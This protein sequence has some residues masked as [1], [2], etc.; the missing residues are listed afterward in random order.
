MQ[1]MK[2]G[3][4]ALRDAESI[5]KAVQIIKDQKTDSMVII[6]SAMDK[7]TNALT[8]LAHLAHTQQE[9]SAWAAYEHI[10]AFHL[11]VC[12]ELFKEHEPIAN[13]QIQAYLDE[14]RNLLQ[15]ILLLGKVPGFWVSGN[16]PDLMYDHIIAYGELLSS[17]LLAHYLKHS[18]VS[19]LWTDVRELVRTDSEAGQ[20][21]V[22]WNLTREN[23]QKFYAEHKV[24]AEIILTQGF[25]GSNLQGQTTTLGREGS[26][27]SAAIFA[28]CLSAEKL[29]VWKDVPGIMSS[30]PKDHKDARLI[31][32]IR[33]EDLAR[34]S[35]FGATVIHPK[36]LRPLKNAGIPLLVKSFLIPEQTGTYIHD[37][38]PELD[39]PVFSE[40]KDQILLHLQRKDFGFWDEAHIA[41]VFRQLDK[42]HVNH[43]LCQI[44]ARDLFLITEDQQKG[45]DDCKEIL[46]KIAFIKI[47]IGL[48]LNTI[49]FPDEKAAQSFIPEEQTFWLSR[50]GKSVQYFRTQESSPNY[51]DE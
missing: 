1:V 41:Y 32:G 18:G 15:G 31:S 36:T 11:K 16:R 2:F 50:I 48:K 3:G 14:I 29:I 42:C 38:A 19:V 5:K 6:V 25:I 44:S 51:S 47:Q 39:I 22:N 35:F 26:D 12:G 43:T 13:T 46:E 7:T 17:T 24:S 34:M 21:E 45:M 37:A 27:Y 4:S 8:E 33:Y 49:R 9:Q 10:S 23:I 40:K 28:E 20:A 30:N